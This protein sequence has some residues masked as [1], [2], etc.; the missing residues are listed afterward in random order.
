VTG[1]LKARRKIFRNRPKQ[2]TADIVGE[3][4]V[5]IR[6]ET[7]DAVMQAVPNLGHV[8]L[9]RSRA[10]DRIPGRHGKNPCVHSLTLA[11]RAANHAA[12]DRRP[13]GPAIFRDPPDTPA[14]IPAP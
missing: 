12:I 5:V 3:N 6:I 8:D 4:Q 13:P 14:Y 10:C 1:G 7:P 9:A 11:D 2:V